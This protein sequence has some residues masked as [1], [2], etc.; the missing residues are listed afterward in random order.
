MVLFISDNW[1]FAVAGTIAG[2]LNVRGPNGEEFPKST[3]S[4]FF[5]MRQG[6]TTR[7]SCWLTSKIPKDARARPG[8]GHFEV[9]DRWVL[10][11][12]RSTL[13]AT[14]R[15][16]YSTFVPFSEDVYVNLTY[17][18]SWINR[19]LFMY[20]FHK[21]PYYWDALKYTRSERGAQSR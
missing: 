17:R 4:H 12:G 19:L 13:D 3:S 11:D 5:Q 18:V 2:E 10:A 8:A 9:T 16:R 21:Y 14:D 6:G 1:E 20:L 15:S 7:A